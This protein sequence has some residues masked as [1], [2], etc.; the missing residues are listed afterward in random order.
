MHE[1][2]RLSIKAFSAFTG[3]NESTLRYYDKIGLLSPESRGD[4][5]YRYYSPVQNFAVEFIKV[6][7][8]VGVP[9]SAIKGMSKTRTPQNVLALLMQQETRLDA[10]L[11]ELQTAY[12]IIHTYRN[13]I[14]A[15]LAARAGDIGVCDLDQMRCTLGQVNDFTGSAT[16]YAAFMEFCRQ[17]H[18]YSINLHYPIGGYY[19][20][21]EAFLRAPAQP[22]RFFSQ[23]PRGNSIRKA[24]KYLVAYNTG[25]YGEFGEL[26]KKVAAHARAH[27]LSLRGPLYIT[28]LLDE[29]SMVD[30]TQYLSQL[31]VGIA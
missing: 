22:T 7:I 9:L 1:V 25:Y 2:T 17:A 21:I 8:K 30:H 15:G 20:N 28:Y 31:V 14:Q 16:F 13:N 27:S 19:E 23:D 18:E 10:Q 4:N 26:P 11:H 6:L 12:A 5:S 24:G 3:I 29:I